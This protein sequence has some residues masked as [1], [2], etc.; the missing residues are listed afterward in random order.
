MRS[1]SLICFLFYF[2][3]YNLEAST[4]LPNELSINRSFIQ[5]QNRF[6]CICKKMQNGMISVDALIEEL[7]DLQSTVDSYT[8]S[9][10]LVSETDDDERQKNAQEHMSKA[11][12]HLIE[13]FE[14]L[15]GAVVSTEFPPLAIYLTY[16][17][18]TEFVEACTEYNT[19]KRIEKG[20]EEP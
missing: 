20:E 15:G 19:A 6:E 10:W 8:A 7:Q 4:L 12:D 1:I 13:S 11:Q 5:T 3:C 18:A 14:Y 16:H 9:N 2:F 17:A